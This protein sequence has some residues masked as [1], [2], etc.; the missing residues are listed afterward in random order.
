M[1]AANQLLSDYSG[2]V[3]WGLG[4]A[5]VI[6]FMVV[7]YLAV[8]V[9]ALKSRYRAMMRGEESG[10]SIEKML[11]DHI[12]ETRRVA[13][14]NERLREENRRIDALLQTA[15]TRVGLVRFSAFENVGGDLSYAVALLD[16]HNN[17]VVFSSIFA[18]DNSR[19]YVKPIEDGRSSY[20]LTRE[21]E[22]AVRDAI[23]S[24]R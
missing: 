23:A 16:A 18:R 3:V 19:S 9:S 14:E 13:E 6:L 24:A 21:E 17:G 22:Q 7:V 1:N 8:S 12:E 15:V 11:L 10:A 2:P 20:T 4:A 5:A